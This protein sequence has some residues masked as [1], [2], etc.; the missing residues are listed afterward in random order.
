[1]TDANLL[2]G[3]LLPEFFP[4]IFGVDENQ[5]LDKQGTIDAFAELAKEVS[6]RYSNELNFCDVIHCYIP[7]YT[8]QKRFKTC[9][10]DRLYR[11]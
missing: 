7:A 5:P 6:I 4:H 3:R 9:I 8:A 11:Y 10:C 2:L 1:M